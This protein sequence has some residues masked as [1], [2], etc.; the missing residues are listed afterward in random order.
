MQAAIYVRVSTEDQARHG[1]SLAEQR[2][3][4]YRRA[5]SLGAASILEFADEGVS[6]ALLDRPGL[7]A[8]REAVREGRVDVIVVR[9][10]DRLSRKLAHQLLLTEE[11]E[12][13]GVRLDFLDFT[14][15]DTPEGKL[16]YSI[17]GAIAEFEKEKIRERMT[18]GKTQKAKQGGIPIGFYNYGYSYDPET[19]TV[20][21]LEEEAA[22]VKNI[23]QWFIE[24]DL[25][26]NGVAKRLNEQGIPTRK[27][28]NLWHRMVVR[29]ILTNPAYKGLWRYKGI[30]IPVPAIIEPHTWD[31]A[32]EKLREARR[33]WAGKSQQD[34]LLSGLVTC[35]DCGNTMTGVYAK[36]WG[37]KDRR[38]TCRKSSQGARNR[39]CIPI[40]M[41]LAAP[42]EAV[43]WEQ[44]C[45]WLQD[46]ECLV[47]A[48]LEASPQ[49]EEVRC[50]LQRIERHLK[51]VE[52]GRVAILDAMAAG[53][54]ELDAQTKNKLGE[55]KRRKERLEQR[56]RELAAALQGIEGAAGKLAEFRALA[57]EVLAKLDELNFAEKKALV[58]ALV[59][60]VIVSGRVSP[61]KQGLNG[62]NVTVLARIPEP[63]K[64]GNITII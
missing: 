56:Q 61:G 62:V 36:W 15:Q 18:R 54:L 31:K 13:A 41:I 45:S 27:R 55:L 28:K 12:K 7:N 10:P 59:T 39:G 32:Q 63:G 51:E 23:F 48:A 49:A 46:P 20:S 25:G 29:Q 19:E 16:F 4:C 57:Q 40:K 8:L 34:Y 35:A 37:V 38:Y 5:V 1:Y 44:V 9:D 60:Q 47:T 6:G 30:D 11:F 26:V 52:K 21:V 24:E 3:A 33:L 64:S 2:D 58:R 14:W 22:V 53:L 17:R 42:V 43:V 50:E